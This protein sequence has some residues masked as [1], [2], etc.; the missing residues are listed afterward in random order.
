IDLF[1]YPIEGDN[2]TRVAPD[3]MVVFGRPKGHRRAYLQFREDNIPPQVVFEIVSES[4]TDK[5][6]ERKRRFYQR[7]GV[8]EYY[9]YDPETSQWQGYV[10]RGKRLRPVPN[11]L[12]WASPLL[13]IRFG[14]G[15]GARVLLYKPDGEPFQS[16]VEL[17]KQAVEERIAREM[18]LRKLRAMGI[19][20]DRL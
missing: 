3:A 14:Q 12:G 6:L 15:N 19:D 5:E 8:Q 4:N 13:G 20:P 1:W 10:R 2:K 18:L 9:V 17:K 7:H 11:M 16:F